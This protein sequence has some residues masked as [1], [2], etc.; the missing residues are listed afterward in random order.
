MQPLRLEP[1]RLERWFARYE[2]SVEHHLCASDCQSM[3]VADLLALEPGADA[4]LAGLW[5]GYTESQGDPALREAVAGLYETISPDDALVFVGAEEAIFLWALADLQPGDRV[6]VMEPCYQSLADV[7]RSLGCRV[8]P[9]PL[10]FADGRWAPDMDLLRRAAPGCKAVVVNSPHNPTGMVMDAGAVAELDALSRDHGFRVFSDEVYRFLE[11]PGDLVP[12]ACD[13]DPRHVSLGVMSKTFG[14]PGLR[15]GWMACRDME[16]ISAV[17]ALKDYTTICSPAP[18]EFLAR[19]ALGHRRALAD[20]S[21]T[22]IA[23]NTALAEAFFARHADRLE[24]LP[25]TAGP[26]AFPRL[27]GADDAEPWCR[28]L[29][30]EHGVL[31]LPGNV[32]GPDW[33]S[34]FRIGLGRD[35][36]AAGLER[37][38]AALAR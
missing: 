29:A 34:H 2:F 16:L 35:N 9:W 21:R 3:T 7:A 6:L 23:A 8:E 36:L 25:P 28:A 37:L 22:V 5:L 27:R 1:F 4:G 11:A 19:I 24:W 32:Y 14:L 10:A 31:L 33:K 26:I 13:R 30:E 20:R 38:E 12:A 18:S 15:I 17:A